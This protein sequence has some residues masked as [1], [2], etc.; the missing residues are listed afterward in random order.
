[1]SK[2]EEQR[3]T[4]SREVILCQNDVSSLPST[5]RAGPILKDQERLMTTLD[6]KITEHS[7]AQSQ[8]YD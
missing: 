7:I 1:M 8:W 6:A 4:F 2:P 5:L 3:D